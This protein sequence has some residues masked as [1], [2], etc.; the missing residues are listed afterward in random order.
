MMSIMAIA[1]LSVPFEVVSCCFDARRPRHRSTVQQEFDQFF[2]IFNGAVF[3][4]AGT[5]LHHCTGC[6]KD[7]NARGLF[8]QFQS[9]GVHAG[10]EG[11]WV[12]VW[13]FAGWLFVI[14][15]TI[16]LVFTSCSILCRGSA[17]RM[18]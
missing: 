17:P 4:H 5:L 11:G 13:V 6:C 16:I 1:Q 2:S 12:G 10:W 3:Q 18:Q 14:L 9:R 7:V 8:L 15:L